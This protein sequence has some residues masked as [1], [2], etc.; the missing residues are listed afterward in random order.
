[1]PAPLPP[2]D[3]PPQLPQS[4]PPRCTSTLTNKTSIPSN[5]PPPLPLLPPPTRQHSFNSNFQNSIYLLTNSTSE[6]STNQQPRDAIKIIPLLLCSDNNSAKSAETLN[7]QSIENL[8][9]FSNLFKEPLNKEEKEQQTPES[10]KTIVKRRKA[11][12]NEIVYIDSADLESSFGGA[13]SSSVSLSSSAGSLNR[14]TLSNPNFDMN[15]LIAK[16]RQNQIRY[17]FLKINEKK[18]KACKK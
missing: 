17:R 3:K 1:V 9:S 16:L 4:H 11:G 15:H 6:P 7:S 10:H 5:P 8:E 12:G 14:S 18:T 2:V 13:S